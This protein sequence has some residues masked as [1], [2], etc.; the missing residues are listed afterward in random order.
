[1]QAPFTEI[2]V[3]LDGSP[4]AERA[5]GPAVELARRTGVPLRALTRALPGEEEELTAYLAG[6][7][8]RF[9]AMADV[10]TLVTGREDIPGAIAE[11]LEPGSLVCMSTHGRGGLARAALGSVAESLLRTIDRPV[12]AVGPHASAG[13]AL[14]GRVVACLDGS[15]EADRTFDPAARWSSALDLPLWLATVVDPVAA[16]EAA[17][18]G[19]VVEAAHLAALA[20]RHP[21]V[22]GWD[23]LHGS[24][25]AAAL[26]DLAGEADVA[27]LVMATHGRTGW[28]RLRLGSVTVGTVRRSPAPVLVV[29]VAP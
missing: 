24:D 2:V 27:V 6:V 10:E 23:T 5:M 1:M 15:A 14:A 21:E 17:A 7:A 11:G 19:D 26:V 4:A 8:D 29:P 22:A 12:L 3:P 20:A 25:P 18:E 13:R 28:D 16:A 9:A